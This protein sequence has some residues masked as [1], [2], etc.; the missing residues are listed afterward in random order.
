M[1]LKKIDVGC[2]E[3]SE[4][5]FNSGEDALARETALINV[6]DRLVNVFQSEYFR[7]IAFTDGSTTFGKDNELVPR[8][9]VLFDGFA[10]DLFRNAIT[11][12]IRCIPLP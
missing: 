6:I 10:N 8:D 2:V 3:T 5:G 9:V 7:V 4:G 11:V 12:D 1:Y